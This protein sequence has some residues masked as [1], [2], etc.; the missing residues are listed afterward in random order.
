MYI[1]L[2]SSL[3]H[4][5]DRHIWISQLN[6]NIKKYSKYRSQIQIINEN[7]E[8]YTNVN[9]HE[10]LYSKMGKKSFSGGAA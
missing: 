7:G 10:E 8:L 1:L 2:Y 9:N 3:D 4:V 6:I 5:V